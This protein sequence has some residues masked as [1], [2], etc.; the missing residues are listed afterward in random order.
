M[1]QFR[2]FKISNFWSTSNLTLK[3]ENELMQLSNEGYEIISV[4]FGYNLWSIPTAFITTR[5]EVKL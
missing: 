4:S 2:I 5:R 3:V 1:K